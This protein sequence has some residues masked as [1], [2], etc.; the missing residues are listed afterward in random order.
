MPPK[1]DDKNKSKSTDD[2]TKTNSP[3]LQPQ[4]KQ[5]ITPGM[6]PGM[7]TFLQKQYNE[8]VK[9]SPGVPDSPELKNG[10]IV[11]DLDADGDL[12][13]KELRIEVSYEKT[14]DKQYY[15]TI[16][17]THT[18]GKKENFQVQL[19]D[20]GIISIGDQ[21]PGSSTRAA[22]F[23]LKSGSSSYSI[24]ILPVFH[25]KNKTIEY[26]FQSVTGKG[27][28]D[29]KAI[30][31]DSLVV[32]DTS[33][34]V[35]G[36][37]ASSQDDL[38][39]DSLKVI[40]LELGVHKDRYNLEITKKENELIASVK[41][42]TSN[43]SFFYIHQI[44]LGN[45]EGESLKDLSFRL[46]DKTN[47]IRVYK[48][49]DVKPI[50]EIHQDM[51]AIKEG[52]QYK[53][54]QN[55]RKIY[56]KIFAGESRE[57]H[58]FQDIMYGTMAKGNCYCQ[59]KTN[60][61]RSDAAIASFSA[62]GSKSLLEKMDASA[63]TAED[64]QQLLS[65]QHEALINAAAR[66]GIVPMDQYLPYI[67]FLSA[68]YGLLWVIKQDKE[69]PGRALTSEENVLIE[70]A[71]GS[72][73]TLNSFSD[74]SNANKEIGLD[75]T[76]LPGK[77]RNRKWDEA[78]PLVLS[79]RS[80]MYA[81]TLKNASKKLEDAKKDETADPAATQ[82]ASQTTAEMKN[83]TDQSSALHKIK[84]E[85][86]V[87]GLVQRVPAI[88][89]PKEMNTNG[90]KKLVSAPI[91]LFYVKIRN[92]DNSEYWR[93]F[94]TVNA[95]GSNYFQVEAPVSNAEE[96]APP[97]S[98]FLE[99]NDK[100]FLPKGYFYYN[101]PGTECNGMIEMTSDLEWDEVFGF[102]A[103]GLLGVGLIAM[104]GGAAAPLV[105]GL[106]LASG[107]AAG[108][109]GVIKIVDDTAEG[110]AS[111]EEITFALI[112]IAGALIPIG[113]LGLLKAANA[114][115][116]ARGVY[117]GLSLF[118]LSSDLGGFVYMT[119]KAA[120]DID[121]IANN[122]QLSNSEKITAITTILAMAAIQSALVVGAHAK[123]ITSKNYLPEL[124]KH[125]IESDFHSA[126]IGKK[127]KAAATELSDLKLIDA[128][129][130]NTIA[131]NLGAEE[132]RKLTGFLAQADKNKLRKLFSRYAAKDVAYM[133]YVHKGDL[134]AATIGLSKL[135]T[136]KW[137]TGIG[138]KY[139]ELDEISN[140]NKAHIR[141]T[142][143]D[144][145]LN[146]QKEARIEDEITALTQ[147]E[148]QLAE[149]PAKMLENKSKLTDAQAKVQA[150]DKTITEKQA[151]ITAKEKEQLLLNNQLGPHKGLAQENDE[152][153]ALKPKAEKAQ[154]QMEMD[155]SEKNRLT[156]E[157]KNLIS[158]FNAPQREADFN[159][160]QTELQNTKKT[161]E[162]R[163]NGE[164]EDVEALKLE[165]EN[166]S[167]EFRRN[168]VSFNKD[169]IKHQETI[170]TIEAKIKTLELEIDTN[171]GIVNEF[172]NLQTKVSNLSRLAQLQEQIRNEKA[173]LDTLRNENTALKKTEQGFQSEYNALKTEENELQKAVKQKPGK[174]KEF[175]RTKKDGEHLEKEVQQ[176]E[177]QQQS[178]ANQQAHLRSLTKALNEDAVLIQNLRTSIITESKSLGAK[179]R[180][181]EADT[182]GNL[183]KVMTGITASVKLFLPVLNTPNPQLLEL[184]DSLRLEMETVAQELN[185]NILL[186]WNQNQRKDSPITDQ[187]LAAL[188]LQLEQEH[189]QLPMNDI[190]KLDAQVKEL[191]K[192][193]Q[194]ILVL[195]KSLPKDHKMEKTID[196]IKSLS[197]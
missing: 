156:E 78:E 59:D 39:G 181:V 50:L 61:T 143:E 150:S 136:F 169:Q 151:N 146:Q 119:G 44:S 84:E 139:E 140:Q 36:I 188:L 71:A 144:I 73:E 25:E 178:I 122:D 43:S 142:R 155:I 23:T 183:Y 101:V 22:M 34:D 100:E 138:S 13:K 165:I 174:E 164:G 191:V 184:Q 147:K 103:L 163:F 149:L 114:Q 192:R 82:A 91:P 76:Q 134:D 89:Y 157:K 105:S 137:G 109:G 108:V 8:S 67:E 70:K 121:E 141:E 170:E 56:L 35:I 145:L 38:F 106:F 116:G 58:E 97:H 68:Y 5:Q 46:E 7:E 187:E 63:A 153:N 132:T 18:S 117:V 185:D 129:I 60:N 49:K 180:N 51:L 96:K 94:S 77:I 133:V 64:H 166:L 66:N 176:R 196:Y 118:E 85:K 29:E 113:K 120:L 21:Y 1:F 65:M 131:A 93:I 130:A 2:S 87:Q 154:Q 158:D 32:P 30:T 80:V 126:A 92:D 162:H 9:N 189:P 186:I 69:T 99:L 40:P 152:L 172:T 175:N 19:P 45:Y 193:G 194:Y 14:A 57:L 17:A 112:D 12:I 128:S 135:K 26:K 179:L 197:K 177:K 115:K 160:Q 167:I 6:K 11:F 161:L 28:K 168:Q 48:N 104:T 27:E 195:G 74:F 90:K 52:D 33:G 81:I 171:K 20:D 10:K 148:K 190:R 24:Y 173:A 75:N 15:V 41:L 102:V 127:G 95:E 72:M 107:L 86:G 98:L 3:Y 16:S 47:F 159:T 110:H 123:R 31:Y 124:D 182:Y 111:G 62:E 88:F 55:I 125:L 54:T 37:A 4:I 42:L 79:V 53:P 83:K